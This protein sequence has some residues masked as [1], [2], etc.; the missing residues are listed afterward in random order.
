MTIVF[1]AIAPHGAP[2]F[3]DVEGPTRRGMEELG[4]RFA[5][6]RPEIAIVLTPPV[7]FLQHKLRLRRGIATLLVVIIGLGLLSAMIY[8]FVKPLAEQAGL[9]MAQLA[10]AWVLQNPNVAAAIIGASRPGQVNDNV[11]AAGVTLDDEVLKRIDDALGN[12][13][14]RDPAQTQRG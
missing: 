7:D 5:A 14:Q 6:A 11:R 3:E 12:V 1:A 10:V 8:A 13:V 9:S 2:V 4:R